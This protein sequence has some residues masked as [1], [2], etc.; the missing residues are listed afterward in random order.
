MRSRAGLAVIGGTRGV[1]L[2]TTR[3]AVVVAVV[4]GLLAAFDSRAPWRPSRSDRER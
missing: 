2:T 3:S 4:I 1:R